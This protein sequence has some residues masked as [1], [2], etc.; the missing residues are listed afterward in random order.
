MS[1]VCAQLEPI[2]IR[3]AREDDA[4]AIRDLILI[5][6][7]APPDFP[8]R[9]EEGQSALVHLGQRRAALRH[10]HFA[11][12]H[13]VLAELGGTVCG[14]MLGYRV[15]RHQEAIRAGLLPPCLRPA[16][17]AGLVGRTSFYINTLACYPQFRNLGIGRQ[18]L[19]EAEALA[20]RGKCRSLSLEVSSANGPALAFYERRGFTVRTT[21]TWPETSV[22]PSACV[23]MVRPV[24]RGQ[25]CELALRAT[26]A[27]PAEG[28]SR[29]VLR[30]VS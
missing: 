21:N 10:Q 18:L 15:S 6:G 2:R 27:P 11:V 14:V 4:A 19:A 25:A 9:A 28:R 8:I 1:V 13:A 30:A 23:L 29:L 12:R 7:D 5:A 22:K 17:D 20:L 3:L 26:A 16:H 24:R